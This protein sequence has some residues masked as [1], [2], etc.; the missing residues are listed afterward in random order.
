[1]GRQIACLNA[2]LLF[3]SLVQKSRAAYDGGKRQFPFLKA[4]ENHE[5]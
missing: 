4:I 5:Y 3:S 2:H 1:M